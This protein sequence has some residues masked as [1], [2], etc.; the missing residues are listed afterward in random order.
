[1]NK[2]LYYDLICSC[3]LPFQLFLIY[4]DAPGTLSSGREYVIMFMENTVE[5]DNNIPLEVFIGGL[6]PANTSS[7]RVTVTYPFNDTHREVLNLHVAPKEVHKIELVSQLKQVRNVGN[8]I[9]DPS[10]KH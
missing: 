7:T 2:I 6:Q 8:E 10:V 1:M 4:L 9:G 3:T 5:I